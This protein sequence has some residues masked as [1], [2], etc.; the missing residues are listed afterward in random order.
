MKK[1]IVLFVCTVIAAS[2]FAQGTINFNNKVSGAVDARIFDVGGETP[3][4]PGADTFVQLYA[5]AGA[6]SLAAV[7]AAT[8]IRGSGNKAGWFK[9]GTV[10]SGLAGGST[11]YFQVRAWKGAASYDGASVRGESNVISV[12]TGGGSP[13]LP[14]S[15]LVGL[16]S[17]SL[18]PEPGTIALAILGAAALFIRRRK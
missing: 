6:D 1:L 15:N 14:P 17:F 7:G 4:E 18:V 11:G 16:E 9:G 2:S 5:G 13:P 10:D 8:A 12:K 3:L